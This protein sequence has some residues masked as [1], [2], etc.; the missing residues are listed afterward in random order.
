MSE[1]LPCPFCGEEPRGSVDAPNDEYWIACEADKCDVCP[2][3]SAR[4]PADALK[5][6]NRRHRTLKR[7]GMVWVHKDGAVWEFNADMDREETLGMK[8]VPVFIEVAK[9]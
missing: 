6:W 2:S 1:A 3:V 9:S 7:I 5:R 4:T 8:Y